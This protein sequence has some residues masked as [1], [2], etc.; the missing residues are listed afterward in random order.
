MEHYQSHIE[1]EESLFELGKQYI[2]PQK[3]VSI[4]GNNGS[5]AENLMFDLIL[6]LPLPHSA[7]KSKKVLNTIKVGDQ[8]EL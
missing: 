1:I 6:R 3:L 2:P 5:K 8:L 7:I 4:G